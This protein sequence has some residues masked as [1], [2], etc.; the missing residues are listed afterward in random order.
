MARRNSPKFGPNTWEVCDVPDRTHILFHAGNRASDVQGCIA[1]G[2][3]LRQDLQGVGSSRV[4]MEAIEKATEGIEETELLII[5]QPLS[6]DV[7]AAHKK[8]APE[9]G[10]EERPKT[11]KSRGKWV[12][13]AKED[14]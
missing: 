5:E 10:E 9:D 3:N 7:F 8:E 1:P 14:A 4:A 13:Q 12:Q 11:R 6:V 2:V